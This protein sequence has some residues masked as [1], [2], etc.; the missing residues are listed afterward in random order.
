MGGPPTCRPRR[1]T[2]SVWHHYLRVPISASSISSSSM[3]QGEGWEATEWGEIMLRGEGT[4][5]GDLTILMD[6][7]GEEG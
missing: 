7:D 3:M 6:T 4:G 5:A 1:G 2:S